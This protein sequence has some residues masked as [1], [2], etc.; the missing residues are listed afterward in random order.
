MLGDAPFLECIEAGSDHYWTGLLLIYVFTIIIVVVLLLNM[1]IA[2]MS[3]VRPAPPC[4]PA[5]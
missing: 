1:I 4:T 5:A 3:K 2:M